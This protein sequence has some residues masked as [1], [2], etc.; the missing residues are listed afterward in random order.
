MH[1]FREATPPGA[2][3]HSTVATFGNQEYLV[4]VRGSSYLS[5]YTLDTLDWLS[6]FKLDGKVTHVM[7]LPHDSGS[8]DDC[9]VLAFEVA[10]LVV[11]KW[12]AETRTLVAQSMHFYE[13]EV[14]LDHFCD[15]KF[16]TKLAVDPNRNCI[17]YLFQ[18]DCL[19]MLPLVKDIDEE[20][21]EGSSGGTQFDSSIIL[22]SSELDAT[23]VNIVDMAYLHGYRDP[24]LAVLY[25]QPRSWTGLLPKISDNTGFMALSID[26][27]RRAS[28]PVVQ[29]IGLPWNLSS[30]VPLGKPLGGCLLMGPTDIIYVTPTGNFS[31]LAIPEG[32]DG[33]KAAH[34]PCSQYAIL[35]LKEGGLR[36]LTISNEGLQISPLDI[37]E[38][39]SL[40]TTVTV[41]SSRIFIGCKGDSPILNY[42]LETIDRAITDELQG[43]EAYVDSTQKD[44]AFRFEDGPTLKGVGPIS[45]VI[46][47]EPHF[48]IAASRGLLYV[49]THAL[50]IASRSRRLDLRRG[51]PNKIWLLDSNLLVTDESTTAIFKAPHFSKPFHSSSIAHDQPTLAASRVNNGLL[52]VQRQAVSLCAPDWKVLKRVILKE[53]CKF[54]ETKGNKAL[55]MY[56]NGRIDVLEAKG[57]SFI[58]PTGTLGQADA[59]A[60]AEQGW[61]VTAKETALQLSEGETTYIL[62]MSGLPSHPSET[63]QYDDDT[64]IDALYTLMIGSVNYVGIL[65]GSSFVIYAKTS[66]GSLIKE[67]TVPFVVRRAPVPVRWHDADALFV[68]GKK[69]YLLTRGRLSAWR[70]VL[71]DAAVHRVLDITS[72]GES[73]AYL[74]SHGRVHMGRLPDIDVTRADIPCQTIDVGGRITALA[75]HAKTGFLAVGT[76]EGRIVIYDDLWREKQVVQISESVISLLCSTLDVGGFGVQFREVLIIGTALFLDQGDAAPLNGNIHVA[77]LSN[78]V[79]PNV[80]RLRSVYP[81]HGAVGNISAVMGRILTSQGR[82]LST[83]VLKDNFEIEPIA[84]LN[85][86]SV[87]QSVKSIRNLVSVGDRI[88]GLKLV[89]YGTDQQRLELL[90]KWSHRIPLASLEIVSSAVREDLYVVVSDLIGRFHL[91]QFDPESPQSD[92]GSNLVP[93]AVAFTGQVAS[94]M[95]MLEREDS[96][97]IAVGGTEDGAIIAVEPVEED[98]FRTLFV[99]TQQMMDKEQPVACLNPR[100]HRSL[101]AEHGTPQPL[102]DLD[103]AKR[104]WALDTRRQVQYSRKLGRHG[105]NHVRFALMSAQYGILED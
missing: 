49:W 35:A 93:R 32:S 76:E 99:I 17:S 31:R 28:M 19:A 73:L 90:S 89:F 60:L 14:S 7:T 15:M 64:P 87:T 18:R 50:D 98:A 79:A 2:V 8:E 34:V 95:T 58:Q 36:L 92:G 1:L 97:L 102:I 53:P 30:I 77:T 88:Q 94:A 25:R 84:F 85:T 45:A 47:P 78:Q 67:F 65:L 80:L 4:V 103:Y 5:V 61:V 40:P 59:C 23:C 33:A 66:S 38:N 62:D 11:L 51:R 74:D 72:E 100:M 69:P 48:L 70:C 44:L 12:K 96:D 37:R 21:S 86:D 46:S 81:V 9:I 13:R 26:L 101:H 42:S 20:T 54:A 27:D 24:T 104:F 3:T 39:F 82:H 63:A 105:L 56:E 57:Q 29:S 16:K 55:L 83:Y 91:F 68:P 22:G 71:V 41:S 43:D 6:E 52:V 10:K 75:C